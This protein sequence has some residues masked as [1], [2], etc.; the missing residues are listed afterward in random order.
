MGGRVGMVITHDMSQEPKWPW[1]ILAQAP[2]TIHSL[3]PHPPTLAQARCWQVPYQVLPGSPEPGAFYDHVSP[4]SPEPG[5][6]LD[7]LAP[8]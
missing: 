7:H 3:R 8:W 6:V 1:A 2:S 5:A 4:G